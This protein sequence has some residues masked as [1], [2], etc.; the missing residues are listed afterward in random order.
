MQRFGAL[1]VAMRQ[2]ELSIEVKQYLKEH[3]YASVVNIGCGLDQIGEAC[4]N[5]KCKIYNIDMPNVI[6]VRN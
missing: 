6:E 5:G 2:I 3:P 4:D 1:E